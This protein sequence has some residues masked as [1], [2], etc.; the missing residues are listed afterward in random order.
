MV[1]ERLPG[2][3][4][5]QRNGCRLLERERGRQR[6]QVTRLHGHILGCRAVAVPVG[7]RVDSVADC[8]PGCAIAQGRDH[9]GDFVGRNYRASVPARAILPGWR[10]AQLGRRDARRTHVHQCVAHSYRWRRRLLVDQPLRPAAVV[11][12]QSVHV[13]LGVELGRNTFAGAHDR[14]L[15]LLFLLF[16]RVMRAG[17]PC[18]SGS[19]LWP[20]TPAC[21]PA[22]G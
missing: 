22:L 17:R 11:Q 21:S 18:G 14:P 16:M 5:G 4:S 7:Q 15:F 20:G 1:E 13:A 2:R 3:Q 8:R 12:A 6:R 19:L 10:P 9:P